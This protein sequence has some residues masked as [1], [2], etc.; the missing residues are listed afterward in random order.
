MPQYYA[1]PDPMIQPA[2]RI[3]VGITNAVQPTVTTSF[4]HDYVSGT[5]VRFVVP[6][7]WG[8]TQLNTQTSEITVTGP[9]T[10]TITIDTSNFDTFVVPAPNVQFR[11]PAQVIP[12]GERNDILSAAVRNVLP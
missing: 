8:M 11:Y 10:F 6:L 1:N 4:D 2:M 3:V 12:I 5:I 7:Q 9:T